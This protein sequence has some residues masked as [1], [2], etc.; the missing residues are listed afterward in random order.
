MTFTELIKKAILLISSLWDHVQALTDDNALLRAALAD[1]NAKITDLS[2][3]SE[4]AIAARTAAEAHDNAT[5]EANSALTASLNDLNSQ[6]AD[7]AAAISA[8][9]E[10]A[11]KVA[12]DLTVTEEKGLVFPAPPAAEKDVLGRDAAPVEPGPP[13]G[14]RSTQISDD[15]TNTV[16]TIVADAP[17]QADADE[18]V[19]HLANNVAAADVPAVVNALPPCPHRLL[20]LVQ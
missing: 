12:P 10:V 15:G 11:L 18:Y 20:P 19:K 14:F 5:Q 2:A 3:T 9:P 8:H 7:L 4:A 13:T 16:T 6:Q 17:T 1:A